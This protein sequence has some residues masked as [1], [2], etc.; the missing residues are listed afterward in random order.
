MS[1]LLVNSTNLKQPKQQNMQQV[2]ANLMH[3]SLKYGDGRSITNVSIM[4]MTTMLILIVGIILQ[5]SKS[6]SSQ[7]QK[8]RMVTAIFLGIAGTL[9]YGFV[10]L[11]AVAY[12]SKT[13]SPIQTSVHIFKLLMFTYF[14]GVYCIFP[15]IVYVK[16]DEDVYDQEEEVVHKHNYAKAV[17]IINLITNILVICTMIYIIYL[18]LWHRDAVV[19]KRQLLVIAVVFGIMVTKSAKEIIDM[20]V[21]K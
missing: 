17:D 5:Y 21:K 2:V 3:G 14:Y 7:T 10:C 15:L 8:R 12:K 20:I 4:M 6:K 1:S 9:L 11:A 18:L 19:L 13:M 16:E